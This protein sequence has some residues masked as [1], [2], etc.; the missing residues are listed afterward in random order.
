MSA[1][2]YVMA[3]DICFLLD[4]CEIFFCYI[5]AGFNQFQKLN[6]KNSVHLYFL[7]FIPLEIVVTV[8]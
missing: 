2:D 8:N 7:S 5:F 6:K 1:V 4:S 3:I